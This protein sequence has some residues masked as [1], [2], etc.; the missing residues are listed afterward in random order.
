M[1]R[2]KRQFLSVF[3]A[4]TMAGAVVAVSSA[5]SGAST[6][7]TAPAKTAPFS[8]WTTSHPFKAAFIY[9]GA[10]SDAGWTHAHDVG[11]R[12]VQKYFGGRVQTLYKED[13]P[14]GPQCTQVITELVNAGANIIFATSYG[15]QPSF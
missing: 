5:S 6:R 12:E 3:V 7:T 14:E 8:K 4:L 11:R 15:Y 9:V 10:P 2:M 13:V 1:S